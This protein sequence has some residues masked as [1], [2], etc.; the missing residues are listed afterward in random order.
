MRQ[1]LLEDNKDLKDPAPPKKKFKF[2]S[3]LLS[4][5]FA[6]LTIQYFFQVGLG[7]IWVLIQVALTKDKT[8]SFF[9]ENFSNFVKDGE[10]SLK[11]KKIWKKIESSRGG[12]FLL[13]E[14]LNKKSPFDFLFVADKEQ[15][16]LFFS[17]FFF[18]LWTIV[19]VV[20]YY[21]ISWLVEKLLN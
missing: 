10:R 3:W 13:D 14:A 18:V 12:K 4:F 11:V 1:S 15:F 8:S 5:F 21:P 7:D 9:V 19:S 20:F 6:Y 17:A 16:S 2:L